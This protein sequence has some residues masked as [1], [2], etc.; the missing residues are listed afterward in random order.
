MPEDRLEYCKKR[1]SAARSYRNA[2]DFY[3]RWKRCY[4]YFVGNHWKKTLP[5]EHPRIVMNICMNMIESV[6]SSLLT[7]SPTGYVVPVSDS[8]EDQR[9]CEAYTGALSYW[10]EENDY[11][12]ILRLGKRNSFIYGTNHYKVWWDREG[13]QDAQLEDGTLTKTGEVV[14]DAVSPFGI[15]HDPHATCLRDCEFI[16]QGKHVSAER[17]KRLA[18]AKLPTQEKVTGELQADETRKEGTVTVYEGWFEGGEQQVWFTDDKVIFSG[19]NPYEHKKFPFVRD[20]DLEIPD[21]YEGIG[22]IEPIMS[23]QREINERRSQG[24]IYSRFHTYP[25]TIVDKGALDTPKKLTNEPNLVLQVRQG[26]NIRRDYAPPMPAHVQSM[27]QATMMDAE[28]VLGVREIPQG[29]RPYSVTSGRGIEAV[30]QVASQRLEGSKARPM[31]QAI[32]ETAK[33]VVSLM[34]QFY[35]GERFLPYWSEGEMQGTVFPGRMPSIPFTVRV[36]PGTSLAVNKVARVQ[37]AMQLAMLNRIDDEE[38]FKALEWPHW[39]EMLARRQEAMMAQGGMPI[40]P[41]QGQR[42]QEGVPKLAQQGAPG[43]I[44]NPMSALGNLPTSEL[45][46][47]LGRQRGLRLS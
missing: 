1:L 10:S 38:L 39:R 20:V 25:W 27:P 41:Q 3:E 33:L 47:R 8:E 30:A 21:E 2:R 7:Q 28:T 34:M 4:N 40:Q 22:M 29:K 5:D 15:F 6:I 23:L 37:L 42:P 43:G 46:G 9:V 19:P 44:G 11:Q 31:E 14:V 35:R 12:R 24:V 18:G 26:M 16:I 32:R 13:G 45:I 36:E 17:L